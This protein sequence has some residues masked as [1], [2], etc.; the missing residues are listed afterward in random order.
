[1]NK[2]THV[3]FRNSDEFKDLY[4]KNYSCESKEKKELTKNQ[5]LIRKICLCAVL[6]AL[7]AVLKMFGI[8]IT[9]NMRISFF[10]LPLIQAGVTSGFGYGIVT[11][12]GADLVYSLFSGYAFNPAFTIS[13]MYW[14][15]LG[16]IFNHY[17]KKHDGK[18]PLWFVIV[19]IFIASILETHTNVL[20]TL[21][22]YGT[23]TTIMQLLT[24]YLVLVI[25]L[26]WMVIVVKVLYERVIKKLHLMD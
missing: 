15:I 21:L 1:M 2:P 8:M 4:E 5:K 14:G 18:L 6:M 9:T 17:I 23:G 22:L 20:V 12:I 19:G 16:G 3:L 13:A 24:K 26:P 7:S 10:A 11:S 25:K